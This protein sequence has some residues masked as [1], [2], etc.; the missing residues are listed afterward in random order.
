MD[1]DHVVG[2]GVGERVLTATPVGGTCKLD[3]LRA[4]GCSA[5]GEGQMVEISWNDASSTTK[6]AFDAAFLRAYAGLVAKPLSSG[7]SAAAEGTPLPKYLTDNEMSWL[8]PYTGFPDAPAPAQGDMKLWSN[9]Q[10]EGSDV[11]FRR[12]E[13]DEVLG[14]AETNLAVLKALAETGVAMVDNVPEPSEDDAA[15]SLKHFLDRAL[16]GLQKD[17]TRDE[18]NWQITK[19]VGATSI[20]YDHDKRLNA[21]TDQ[22]VPPHGL[23]GVVLSMNYVSGQGCNTLVDGFAVARKM[24]E[25]DPEA[26]DLLTRYGYDAER[27]FVASRVDSEQNHYKTLIV[28]RKNR[29]F[30]LDADGEISKIMYNEVF[31]TPAALP[32]ELFPKWFAALELFNSLIHN[33]EFERTIPMKAGTILLMNNWR[34]LHGRVGGM[35]SF[36]RKLVGGTITRESYYSTA[37]TLVR[38]VAGYDV[39]DFAF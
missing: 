34:I 3:E 10:G 8:R 16:G 39:P 28:S 4:T 6:S 22:S 25:V 32:F 33:P 29:I 21:H 38:K 15:S 1:D 35:A 31:R 14:D 2:G 9:I 20:S 11:E 12:F 30:E 19:K 5:G 24:R 26:F 23:P 17:P 13:H 36:D 7:A 18:P 27:D 37:R